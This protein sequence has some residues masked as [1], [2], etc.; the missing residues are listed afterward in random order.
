[1]LK[2]QTIHK[3][4]IKTIPTTGSGGLL[5]FYISRIQH[6]LHNR[7]TDGVQG[8]RLTQRPRSAPQEH[9]FIYVC[10]AEFW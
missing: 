2:I 9:F 10:D 8:M 6:F 1:M 5:V 4:A 3:N 7:L